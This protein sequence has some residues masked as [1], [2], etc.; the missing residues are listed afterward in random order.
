M[1]KH[2][3]KPQGTFNARIRDLALREKALERDRDW[4]QKERNENSAI[5]EK[6]TAE[7]VKLRKELDAREKAISGSEDAARAGKLLLELEA[8]KAKTA[9]ETWYG[10]HRAHPWGY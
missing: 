2:K 8:L 7:L 6:R 4:L 9:Y 3:P 5:Y 10:L 1:R